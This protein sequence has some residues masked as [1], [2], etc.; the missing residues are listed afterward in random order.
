MV[1]IIYRGHIKQVM[2]TTWSY[3]YQKSASPSSTWL[4]Y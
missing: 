3:Q 1:I 2:F 4:S